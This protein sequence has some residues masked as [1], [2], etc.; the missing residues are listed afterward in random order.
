MLR[1][2]FILTL[3]LVATASAAP[4]TVKEIDF[5][6]RQRTPEAEISAQ[7][8]ERRLL[9]ALD[10]TGETQLVEH[11]ATPNLIALL[12]QGHLVL[13]PAEAQSFALRSAPPRPASTAPAAPETKAT[14]PVLAQRSRFID[15]LAGKLV[16]LEG[17]ELKPLDA[18][19][20]RDVRVFAIYSSAMWCG[21]CRKF[22]PKL[23]EYYKQV[24]AKHP[25]FEVIF[26]SSDRDEF[27]MGTYMRSHH[28]PWPAVRYG[29]Q[30]E[31]QQAFCGSSIPWLVCVSADG[32][33]LTK[34]GEDKKYIAPD[35]VL[36]AIDYLLE[37]IK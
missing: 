32:R 9:A 15:Q 35:E 25:N 26:L 18:E 11:G 16:K 24:K 3:A 33:S 17:D 2:I 34:N 27:N 36:G 10:R 29:A 8:Q 7:L 14:A 4:M 19:R 37:Q 5:L 6:L 30:A 1:A 12:K 31:L 23:V 13:S 22:T 20:L 28:M 21:P